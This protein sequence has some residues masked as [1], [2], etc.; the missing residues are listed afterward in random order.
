[1]RKVYIC[2][3]L[4]IVVILFAACSTATGTLTGAE[5]NDA[6]VGEYVTFGSYEQDNDLANGAEDIEWLVLEKKDGMALLFSKYALDAKP[7]NDKHESVTWENCTLRS[8]LNDD[9][10][11]AAFSEME[12]E[13]I[14]ETL[15]VNADNPVYGTDGGND[16]RDKVFLLSI[17]EVAKYFA[18]DLNVS[19]SVRRAQVTEYAKSQGGW[20][21][22]SE[23]YYGNGW[24]WLRSPGNYDVSAAIVFDNGSVA[25]N[26][27]FVATYK[28][29]VCPAIWITY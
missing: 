28:D 5:A 13:R 10:Y 4:C 21:N 3:A 23:K 1:M 11:K 8:W 9:F 7:Y 19:D 29:V 2:F 24:W 27:N 26:G 6:S 20:Y 15:V 22:E 14:I 18:P 12:R 25:C 17:D 16:T